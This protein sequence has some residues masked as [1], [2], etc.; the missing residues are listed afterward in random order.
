MTQGPQKGREGWVASLLPENRAIEVV[1]TDAGIV[2]N[3]PS[4]YR[5]QALSQYWVKQLLD[6]PAP[7]KE[8]PV[9]DFSKLNPALNA[10]RPAPLPTASL[11][12]KT[13]RQ[14]IHVGWQVRIIGQGVRGKGHIATVYHKEH[15]GW[16]Y[17]KYEGVTIPRDGI[18]HPSQLL[19]I[20]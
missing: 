4:P 17:V 19:D 5:Y 11:I 6:S 20:V 9:C 14:D 12:E 13:G 16:F 7:V 1:F 10:N 8:V 3:L 15:N 2:N 18:Y